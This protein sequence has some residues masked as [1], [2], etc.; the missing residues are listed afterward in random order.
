MLL[1]STWPALQRHCPCV[2][3]PDVH[4]LLQLQPN[5]AGLMDLVLRL[6]PN[7]AA[8]S[9]NPAPLIET[10]RS[11]SRLITTHTCCVHS[12]SNTCLKRQLQSAQQ[13]GHMLRQSCNHVPDH[14]ASWLH[15]NTTTP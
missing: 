8:W 2:L 3:K 5:A 4:S 6:Q 7:A 11:R 13:L 1:L 15:C 9:T 10:L 12:S 14:H